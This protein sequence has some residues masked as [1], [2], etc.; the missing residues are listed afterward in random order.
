MRTIAI[1]NQKGGTGLLLSDKPVK[2]LSAA[3]RLEIINNNRRKNF[4]D[5]NPNIEGK[6]RK[7]ILEGRIILGMTR[8]MIIASWGK[9]DDINRHVGS[10]GVKEQFV[11]SSYSRRAYVYIENGKLTSWSD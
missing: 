10:W 9:P 11:Y 7:A 8:E 3:E 2:K 6:Y 1:A 4:V 5:N